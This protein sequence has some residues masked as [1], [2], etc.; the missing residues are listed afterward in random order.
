MTDKTTK[1]DSRVD[2]SNIQNSVIIGVKQGLDEAAIEKLFAKSQNET[3]EYMAALFADY[4]ASNKE[5]DPEIAANHLERESTSTTDAK[6]SP[7]VE[8]TRP[9][10][11]SLYVCESSTNQKGL[12]FAI[13]NSGLLVT[14]SALTDIVSATSLVA[15]DT[16]IDASLVARGP[17][18]QIAKI[19]ALTVGITLAFRGDPELNFDE[20][21]FAVDKSGARQ[22]LT[23]TAIEMDMHV[24]GWDSPDSKSRIK[25]L[26]ECITETGHQPITGGPVFTSN[27]EVCGVI[28]AHA[29]GSPKRV[30]FAPWVNLY[31]ALM[32]S[33]TVVE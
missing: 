28:V 5:I 17:L 33:A 16:Q 31:T 10:A 32:P 21:L 22:S 26:T 9:L 30:Y 8:Q 15:K 13:N 2:A 4:F 23:V 27:D 29:D 11:V 12:G 1:I 7:L 24:W 14:T 6:G 20:P 18:L 25:G 3:R 19:D